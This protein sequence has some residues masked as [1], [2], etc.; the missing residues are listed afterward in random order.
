LW[1]KGKLLLEALNVTDDI[2][3]EQQLARMSLSAS[4]TTISLCSELRRW[5]LRDFQMSPTKES[6]FEVYLP[7]F[8]L[9]EVV[10]YSE[11]KKRLE[12]IVIWP[13]TQRHHYQRLGLSLPSGVLLF[14]PPGCGKTRIVHALARQCIHIHFLYVKG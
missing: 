12:E 6:L 14:G 8:S 13:L 11:V 7:S 4:S 10:G 3:P 1:T 5:L 2:V 9:D